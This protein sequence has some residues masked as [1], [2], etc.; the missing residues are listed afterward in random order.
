MLLLI[1]PH[2]DI[3]LHI[4]HIGVGGLDGVAVDYLHELEVEELSDVKGD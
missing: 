4:G 1:L 3:V 2:L